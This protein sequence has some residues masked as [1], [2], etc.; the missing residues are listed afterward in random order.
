MPKPILSDTDFIRMFEEV[1]P[2]AMARQLKCT[3]SKIFPRRRSI[4]RRI[5]RPLKSPI[6][7]GAGTP[8]GLRFQEVPGRLTTEIRN[9]V[10]LVGSDPHYW[11]GTSN[12]IHR[13]FVAFCKEYKP[14]L[15][16]LNGDVNDF[17]IISRHPRLRWENLP[18]VAE[19]IEAAK[20]RLSEI[21]KAA[22]RARKVFPLGNHDRRFETRLTQGA[23]EYAK[24]HGVHLKDHYPLWEPCW[25]IWINN[26][27][28]V[29]HRYKGGVGHTRADALNSGK[30]MVTGDKH[31]G[32]ITRFTDY[33]G[34]RWGVDC[35]MMADPYGPQ[36]EYME[37]NPRDW[38]S[39]FA[40]LTFDKEGRLLWPELVVAFDA[41]HVQ[42][43]G[44]VIKC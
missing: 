4:E 40:F 18:T 3:V 17:G 33:N 15:V 26:D 38:C 7:P 11:P 10:V 9:A 5:G 32:N 34:D 31:S 8:V 35:G 19:E 28:V 30:T 25:S 36:F 39:S 2:A 1:G 22:F 44:E 41:E 12:V 6:A 16:I 43:R 13:A 42:F 37:D 20:E 29:K 27:V 23:P 14:P 24:V 21:E